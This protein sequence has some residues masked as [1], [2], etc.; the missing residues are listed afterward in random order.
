MQDLAV[1][2]SLVLLLALIAAIPIYLWHDHIGSSATQHRRRAEL[3]KSFDGRPEVVVRLTGTGMSREETIWL[4]RQHGYEIWKWETYNRTGLHMRMRRVQQPHPSTG[5][6]D[7]RQPAYPHIPNNP[8]QQ[9][10]FQASNR[11][12]APP[13][14]ELQNIRRELGRTRNPWSWNQYALPLVGG[15]VVVGGLAIRDLISDRPYFVEAG[16]SATCLASA[17]ATWAAGRVAARRKAS[18]L[19]D[20]A[21]GTVPPAQGTETR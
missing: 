9:P 11:L 21:Q 20:A 8:Y 5:A 18:A 10:G 19:K 12:S 7:A 16:T 15:A 1:I 2:G 14:S 13:P 3:L 17:A 6:V 4:A